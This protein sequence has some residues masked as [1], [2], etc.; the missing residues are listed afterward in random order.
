MSRNFTK[1][2]IQI[3]NMHLKRCSVSFY[4][5]KMRIR[6]TVRYPWASTRTRETSRRRTIANIGEA[7]EQLEPSHRWNAN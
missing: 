3:D 2:D 4:I 5:R 6:I 7:E 1:E